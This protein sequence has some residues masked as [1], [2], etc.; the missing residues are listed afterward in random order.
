MLGK[1]FKNFKMVHVINASK[2][3][4][5]IAY[6]QRNREFFRAEGY[7]SEEL[8]LDGKSEDDVRKILKDKEL[9]YVEG[10]N[11]F[12][13]LKSIRES[14]FEKVV[15]ELLPEGLVYVGASA[16]AYVACPTIEMAELR[17]QDKY[18]HYGVTDLTAM[19]LV[20]F[21]LSVH[22]KPEYKEILKEKISKT[23]YPVKILTDEQALLIQ[24]GEVTLVGDTQEIIL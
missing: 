11:T 15:K 6:V 24:D 21:L 14:G 3:V 16:G 9:V 23:T 18:D 1:S 19:S 22:Y 5:D 20:P 8:D 12:C 7:N 13:L 17:H 2:G 10:G 4:S